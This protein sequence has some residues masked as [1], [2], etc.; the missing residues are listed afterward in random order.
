MLNDESAELFYF[1]VHFVYISS[2]P[3]DIVQTWL[4]LT[5]SRRTMYQWLLFFTADLCFY[6]GM[7]TRSW[8]VLIRL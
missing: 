6:A 5:S 2:R 8:N 1:I 4:T 7:V 3:A